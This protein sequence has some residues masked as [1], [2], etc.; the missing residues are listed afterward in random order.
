MQTNA[1]SYETHKRKPLKHYSVL[2]NQFEW[3]VD[4]QIKAKIKNIQ[5]YNTKR[6]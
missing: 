1:K 3:V 2:N 6:T 4:L 5:K